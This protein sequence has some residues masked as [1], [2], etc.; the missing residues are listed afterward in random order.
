MGAAT[1]IKTCFRKCAQFEGRASRAE[2]WWFAPMY[3][4]LLTAAFLSELLPQLISKFAFV[5][6]SQLFLIWLAMLLPV[7]AVL[8]RRIRDAGLSPLWLTAIPLYLIVTLPGAIAWDAS[9]FGIRSPTRGAPE[10]LYAVSGLF[11][12][13]AAFFLICALPSWTESPSDGPNPNE[14]SP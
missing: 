4:V 11:A 2:F 7:Y 10:I 5:S 3:L 1:A 9:E 8:A 12:V 14:V 13:F 6:V